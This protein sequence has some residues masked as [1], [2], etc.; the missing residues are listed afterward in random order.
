MAVSTRTKSRRV[1][2]GTSGSH[3]FGHRR[4]ADL[5]MTR[6]IGERRAHRD[7]IGRIGGGQDEFDRSAAIAVAAPRPCS[8]VNLSM[9]RTIAPV[10]T[11]GT[12][13]GRLVA[14]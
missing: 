2:G 8:V 4:S 12:A 1:E 14:V 9:S 10:V 6:R 3:R 13:V 11:P 5:D 7:V